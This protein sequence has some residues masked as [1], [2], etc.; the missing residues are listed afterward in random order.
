[1][2]S[3]APKEV[4]HLSEIRD[5]TANLLTEVCRDVCVEPELQPLN[6]EQMEYVTSNTQDGARLD[7]AANGLWGGRHERTFFD[8]RVFNP[9]ATETHSSRPATGNTR[10]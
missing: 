4:F 7:I 6:G 5:M 3:R 9:H 10:G 2:H 8:V 1:M